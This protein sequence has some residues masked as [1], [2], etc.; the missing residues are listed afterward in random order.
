MNIKDVAALARFSPAT[1]SRC[2]NNTG[3]LNK[4]TR[5]R[6]EK[7]VALIGYDVNFSSKKWTGITT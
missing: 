2:L 1:V 6:I 4:D 3:V 7:I 5:V